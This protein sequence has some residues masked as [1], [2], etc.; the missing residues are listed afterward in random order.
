MVFALIHHI[1][2][3]TFECYFSDLG[4]YKKLLR[5]EWLA[6]FAKVRNLKVPL[7]MYFLPELP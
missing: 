6:Y 7:G 3:C 4:R 1:L 5:N 2:L